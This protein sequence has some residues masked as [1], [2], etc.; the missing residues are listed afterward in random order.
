MSFFQITPYFN[1][2][3]IPNC[4]LWLDGSDPFGTGEIPPNY[5]IISSFKDKS[6]NA[7]SFSTSG[8]PTFS[9]GVYNNNGL[10]VFNGSTMLVNSSFNFN[11]S[12]RSLFLVTQQTFYNNN[13]CGILSFAYDTLNDATLSNTISYNTGYFGASAYQIVS[14]FPGIFFNYVGAKNLTPFS[15]YSDTNLG[16]Q[17]SAYINGTMQYF[18]N[19]SI[20]PGNSTGLTIGRRTNDSTRFFFGY[21]AEIVLYNYA[22]GDAERQQVEGYLSQKWGLKSTLP[23]WHL[24]K[25]V[26]YYNLSKT[27]YFYYSPYEAGHTPVNDPTIYISKKPYIYSLSNFYPTLFGRGLLLWLDAFDSSTII[28]SGNNIVSSWNDKSGYGN[29]AIS[30]TQTGPLWQKWNNNTQD[31]SIKFDGSNYMQ[32]NTNFMSTLNGTMFVVFRAPIATSNQQQ[33]VFQNQGAWSLDDFQLQPTQ[34]GVYT[35][36]STIVNKFPSRLSNYSITSIEI[37]NQIST[38]NTY[39]NGS[40]NQSVKFSTFFSTG[41]ALDLP[42]IGTYTNNGVETELARFVGDIH[43][44]VV[45][46]STLTNGMREAMEGYLAWKWYEQERLPLT[47]PFYNIYPNC[48]AAYVSISGLTDTSIQA[49]PNLLVWF[50]FSRLS[51]QALIGGTTVSNIPALYSAPGNSFTAQGNALINSNVLSNTVT[52]SNNTTLRFNGGYSMQMQP[53]GS[54]YSSAYTII[55][56]Y[57]QTNEWNQTLMQGDGYGAGTGYFYGYFSGGKQQWHQN[58]WIAGDGGPAGRTANSDSNWDLDVFMCDGNANTVYRTW[59]SN[60]ACYTNNNP[61]AGI[62]FNVGYNWGQSHGQFQELFVFTS[63]ISLSN[64]TQIE[65]YLAWKYGLQSRLSNGH[66]YA[67]INPNGYTYQTILANASYAAANNAL[68]LAVPS[69]IRIFLQATSWTGSGNWLDL[70]LNGRD[71]FLEDGTAQKNA[72]GNGI[73][74]NGATCWQ[75]SNVAVGNA[76]TVGFWYYNTG[77]IQGLGQI[78]TQ[79]YN[80]NQMNINIGQWDVL[81]PTFWEPG[82]RS[83]PYTPYTSCNTWTNFQ[84]TWDGN[85]MTSYVNGALYG[86]NQPG[87][88]SSDCGMPYRIGRR[89]DSAEYV[90]GVIGE[91][92]IYNVALTAQE[93]LQDYNNTLSLYPPGTT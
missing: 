45:F 21:I 75:F 71:A 44:I 39:L 15:V 35:P 23:D 18:R 67:T 85:Y 40:L 64:Y 9:T 91:L 74:L 59:G 65:G 58:G 43:E 54:N 8:A 14:Q 93:V 79:I 30:Q 1:P 55:V 6:S 66:P 86:Q 13:N 82:V 16:Q 17:E 48:N 10:I 31:Q 51:Q 72:N 77:G 19:Y 28:T 12:N 34:W 60:L 61:Y 49:F 53:I 11:L 32:I 3:T 36:V 38:I 76:W 24:G 33:M 26:T 46:N 84:A 63:N 7:V 69:A 87:G 4:A 78:V 88:T 37:I 42:N 68:L 22:L 47:H 2:L 62:S 5:S 29:N 90:I 25:R 80:G 20:A 89:W 27:A 92:R 73:I 83:G 56:L 57:R 81:G 70:S 52:P 41:D 50:D